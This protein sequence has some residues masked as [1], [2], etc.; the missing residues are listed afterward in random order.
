MVYCQALLQ[1]KKPSSGASL[2]TAFADKAYVALEKRGQTA[3]ELH[4][5]LSISDINT[6]LDRLAAINGFDG[7]KTVLH[8]VLPLPYYCAVETGGGSVAAIYLSCALHTQA[9]E[10]KVVCHTLFA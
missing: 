6:Y 7:K 8:E 10:C 2:V 3:D 5:R 4:T 9:I 1:W